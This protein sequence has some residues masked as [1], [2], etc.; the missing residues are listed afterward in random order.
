MNSKGIL[1]YFLLLI[2]FASV[3]AQEKGDRKFRMSDVVGFGGGY[4]ENKTWLAGAGYFGFWKDD[5]IRYRGAAGYA[6]VN[7]K[8]YGKGGDFLNNHPADFSIKAFGLV[9]QAIF[10]IR[11][12]RFLIGGKYVLG[13]LCRFRKL[14]V[15]II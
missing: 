5:H 7:L 15:E 13:F 9:Q 14:L 12:S 8:Y 4:T 6:D 10:R 11:E 3:Y 2:S 1:L